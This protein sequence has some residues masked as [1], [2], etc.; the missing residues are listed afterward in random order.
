MSSS[1]TTV[2]FS[3]STQSVHSIPR[4]SATM[5]ADWR[6]AAGEVRVE[7]LRVLRLR[8]DLL[9]DAERLD[10]HPRRVRRHVVAL[11][12]ADLADASRVAGDEQRP[13]VGD[14]T[15]D[16]AARGERRAAV[17]RRRCR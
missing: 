10:L 11:A 3:A 5:F 6:I 4:P 1:A 13:H 17:A 9:A 15:G 7:H 14:Q 2:R 12:G 16:V 8:A